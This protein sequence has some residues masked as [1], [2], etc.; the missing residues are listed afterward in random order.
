MYSRLFLNKKFIVDSAVPNPQNR[1]SSPSNIKNDFFGYGF[2]TQVGLFQWYRTITARTVTTKK[3]HVTA[4][5]HTYAAGNLL[6]EILYFC[7]KIAQYFRVL[8]IVI[9]LTLTLQFFKT[10]RFS[11]FRAVLRRWTPPAARTRRLAR[12]I[13]TGTGNGKIRI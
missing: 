2:T 9:T 5:F 1:P 11:V 6:L 8:F 3:C 4:P 12:R 13:G 10:F 7:F